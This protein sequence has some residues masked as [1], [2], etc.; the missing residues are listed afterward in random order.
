MWSSIFLLPFR[1]LILPDIRLRLWQP[2]GGT[3]HVKTKMA[4][5]VDNPKK[6]TTN[7]PSTLSSPSLTVEKP[8]A[9]LLSVA[10]DG[11]CL[12]LYRLGALQCTEGILSLFDQDTRNSLHTLSFFLAPLYILL[13]HPF[14]DI[15]IVVHINP[16]T[17]NLSC[18]SPLDSQKDMAWIEGSISMRCLMVDSFVVAFGNDSLHNLTRPPYQS[19]APRFFVVYLTSHSLLCVDRHVVL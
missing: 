15:R 9:L 14:F 16:I 4:F 5:I 10:Y 8:K 12:L 13:V 18:L 3:H 6:T 2:S 19:I 11:R 7:K 17:V 1:V